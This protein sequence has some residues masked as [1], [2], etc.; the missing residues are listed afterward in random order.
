MF[1][2]TATRCLQRPAAVAVV[3]L[4]AGCG[5]AA[6][7]SNAPRDEAACASGVW[8]PEELHGLI[9]ASASDCGRTLVLHSTTPAALPV[10]AGPGSTMAPDWYDQSTA[11]RLLQRGQTT[12]VRT[13]N[14][15]ASV[16][17]RVR[18]HEARGTGAAPHEVMITTR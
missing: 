16:F 2:V 17:V 3:L 1:S 10:S 18:D 12:L 4:L 7:R 6:A 11:T 8:L 13:P 14:G 15:T 5:T 9:E